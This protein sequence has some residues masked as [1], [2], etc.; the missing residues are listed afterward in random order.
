MT[1]RKAVARAARALRGDSNEAEHDALVQLH[2]MAN[3]T[4]R[5]LSGIIDNVQSYPG[6]ESIV[7]T[8][9]TEDYARLKELVRK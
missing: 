6:G 4:R 8:L 3:D 1:L 5:A 7:Y 2:N 9:D